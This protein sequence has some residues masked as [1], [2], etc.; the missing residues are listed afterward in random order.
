M[1]LKNH[2]KSFGDKL[3]QSLLV[4][5]ILHPG[6]KFIIGVAGLLLWFFV[7][8]WME[9]TYIGHLC[10]SK[11]LHTAPIFALAGFWLPVFMRLLCCLSCIKNP[12]ELEDEKSDVAI[13]DEAVRVWRD[14]HNKPHL[15]P[16]IDRIIDVVVGFGFFIVACGW[17][18]TYV[19]CITVIPWQVTALVAF[20]T[21]F[22][23]FTNKGF[24]V[25]AGLSSIFL[26]FILN[27]L[28]LP[29]VSIPIMVGYSLAFILTGF[30]LIYTGQLFPSRNT[31]CKHME[32][33]LKEV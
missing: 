7:A 15:S 12:D 30:F 6:S 11:P 14:E 22:L 33:E 19:T 28:F 26:A 3:N 23:P 5:F 13:V 8:G 24:V 29:I 20:I 1:K 17:I 16:S 10:K 4:E 18:A 27:N 31:V 32:E 9:N 21:F 2:L 25:V